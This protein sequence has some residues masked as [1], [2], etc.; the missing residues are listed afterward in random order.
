MSRINSGV[1][2]SNDSNYIHSIP[3]TERCNMGWDYLVHT[4]PKNAKDFLDSEFKDVVIASAMHGRNEYYAACR[5]KKTGEVF[6][7]VVILDRK[8]G[9]FGWKTMSEDMGPY[10]SNCPLNILGMLTP[11]DSTYANEWRE[12]CRNN[13]TFKKSVK[14]LQHGD[15]VKF[16]TPLSFG[17]YGKEDRFTVCKTGRTVRFQM[18]KNGMLCRI[19]HWQTRPF[20][21]IHKAGG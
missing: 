8:K 15:V 21:I 3:F 10:Y 19:T 4:R 7:M 16:N 14:K 18:E 20:T 9:E 5:S 13:A 6:G 17:P 1:D 11:T 2:N 12:R